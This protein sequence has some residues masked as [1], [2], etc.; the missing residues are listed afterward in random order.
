MPK[1]LEGE[2]VV[3]VCVGVEDL[4]S[5]KGDKDFANFAVSIG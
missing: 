5:L 2:I 1:T 3:G 4:A